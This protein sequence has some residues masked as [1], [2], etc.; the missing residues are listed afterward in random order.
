[1]NME[2]EDKM[3]IEDGEDILN[4]FLWLSKKALCEGRL[5]HNGRRH[6]IL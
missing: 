6:V 5:F 1:M 3:F 2:F 4:V